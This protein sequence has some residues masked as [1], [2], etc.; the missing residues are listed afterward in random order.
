MKTCI[1]CGVAKPLGEFYLH[2]P[3]GRPERRTSQCK[4]CTGIA[5]ADYRKRT[6]AKRAQYAREWQRR[7]LY[8]VTPEKFESMSA[9]ADDK[10]LGCEKEVSL[11]VDHDHRTGRI[12]GLLCGSCNRGL[13]LLQDDPETLRRLLT[14][15]KYHE[16]WWRAEGESG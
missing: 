10:C 9:S 12:R 16:W 7:K 1:K 4:K 15:L 8:G 14:Y 11:Q 2:R 6:R 5:Q 13:G 3:K